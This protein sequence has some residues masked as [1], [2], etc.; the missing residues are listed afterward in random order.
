MGVDGSYQVIDK[1]FQY[2]CV[3]ARIFILLSTGFFMFAYAQI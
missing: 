2:Q 1:P 3:P